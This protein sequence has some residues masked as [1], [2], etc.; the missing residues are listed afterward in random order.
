MI[1]H[2]NPPAIDAFGMALDDAYATAKDFLDGSPIETQGQADA[3]GR[4]VSEVKKIRK[5]ADAARAEEKRPHDEAAKAVQA[6]WKPLLDRADT[7]VTAAQRPL[8]T[9]L[10]KL[11]AQQAEAE[12]LARVEAERAAQAAIE[13]QRQAD[14]VEAI[15][16]AKRLQDEADKAAKAANKAGKAKAHVAGVDRAVGLRSH[17]VATVTDHRAALLWIAKND[18]AAVNAF[19]EDYARRNAPT[20]PMDGVEVTTERRVA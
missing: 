7:I 14:G 17:R 20:R 9:Y 5:D 4:I 8:T 1:G 19:V 10:A 2:N 3:I 15:E 6:K 13:A 18:A 12:R 16:Q 11:A